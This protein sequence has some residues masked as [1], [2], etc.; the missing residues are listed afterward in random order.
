MVDLPHVTHLSQSRRSL[1]LFQLV[2][3]LSD[4][5]RPLLTFV[6]SSWATALQRQPPVGAAKQALADHLEAAVG[7]RGRRWSVW[8][9]YEVQRSYGYS[10][11]T[12][13]EPL[14]ASPS[15]GLAVSTLKRHPPF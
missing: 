9:L 1:G 4:S 2:L 7:Q 8:R 14:T 3:E 13:A 12:S 15:P 5:R 11:Q 10:G 6:I